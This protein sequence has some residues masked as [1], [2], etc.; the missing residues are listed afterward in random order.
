MSALPPHAAS[1]HPLSAQAAR[2]W[3]LVAAVVLFGT[4][5]QHLYGAVSWQQA[6]L[7]GVG[8]LLGITLYHSS[9]GFTH[10]WRVFVADRKSAGL[11]TQMLMLALGVVLFF[12]FLSAGELAGTPVQGLRAPLGVSLV[13][14]AFVFGLGMQLGGGCASGTLYTVGGGNTRMMV[15]LAA[16]IVGGVAATVHL[17]WWL[18]LPSVPPVVLVE[19]WGLWPALATFLGLFALIAWA[20]TRAERRRH[21]HVVPVLQGSKPSVSLLRGPWPLVWGAIGLV[22]LNFATLWLSGRPWGVT[23]ALAL[24]GAKALTA[25]GVDLSGVSYW[26]ARTAALEAPLGDDVTTVMNVGIMLGAFAAATLAG[27]YR[28]NWHIPARSLVAAVLGGLLMGYGSRLSFGCNIGAYFS[29][30]LSSS[31]HAWIWLPVAFA[32]SAIGVRMRPLFGLAVEKTPPAS[33]C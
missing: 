22:L 30:M 28:W 17:D 15:T 27:K 24:W 11:R 8:L 26:D 21:G 23:S 31:V 5:A 33:S 4:G 19:S 9:F 12:P 14:G 25:M 32:G 3:P 13:V 29:G 1:A 6:A 16:F 18:A 7:W 2:W 10:A 20:C